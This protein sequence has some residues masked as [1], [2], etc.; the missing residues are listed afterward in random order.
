MPV[1]PG[2]AEDVRIRKAQQRVHSIKGAGARKELMEILRRNKHLWITFG[3][4]A[5]SMGYDR[6]TAFKNVMRRGVDGRDED[7]RGDEPS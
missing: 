6:G 7:D 2:E 5:K 4:Q 1:T 3:D